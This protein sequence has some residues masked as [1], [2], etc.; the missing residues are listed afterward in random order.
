MNTLI[1]FV[2]GALSGIIITAYLMQKRISRSE[3][4]NKQLSIDAA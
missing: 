2:L 3:Q 4:L 1:F